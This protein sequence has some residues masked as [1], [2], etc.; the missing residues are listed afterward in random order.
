MDIFN[1]I[2]PDIKST[3][4]EI[5]VFSDFRG[6][7]K[8]CKRQGYSGASLRACL[9][10]LRIEDK[11]KTR[12]QKKS[13]AQ[14]RKQAYKNYKQGIPSEGATLKDDWGEDEFT[15]QRGG[16]PRGNTGSGSGDISVNTTESKNNV[17]KYALIGGIALVVIVGTVIAIK[18]FKK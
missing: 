13:D 14:Q 2:D 6:R 15:D 7:R 10:E 17:I 1:Q 9:K 12:S 4:E 5:E 16:A 18:K 8:E 11:S 3:S